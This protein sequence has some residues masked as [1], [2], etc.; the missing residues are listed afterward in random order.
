[1]QS[2]MESVLDNLYKVYIKFKR[3]GLY[4]GKIFTLVSEPDPW[5]I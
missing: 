4:P 2:A 3:S 5:L 1:M